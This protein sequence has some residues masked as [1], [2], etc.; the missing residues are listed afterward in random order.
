MPKIKFRPSKTILKTAEY[1]SIFLVAFS[2]LFVVRVSRGLPTEGGTLTVDLQTWDRIARNMVGDTDPG[3]TDTAILKGMLATGAEGSALYKGT[4]NSGEP[5]FDGDLI[6]L[7]YYQLADGTPNVDGTNLFIGTWTPITS[8]TTIG[9]RFDDASGAA[10]ENTDTAN[11]GEF[12]YQIDFTREGTVY[13][14]TALI[15]DNSASGFKDS[16]TISGLGGT[17]AGHLYNLD[18]VTYNADNSI[19]GAAP[20]DEARLGIRVYDISQGA[21]TGWNGSNK[22][23][24]ATKYQ[25]IMHTDWKWDVIAS[26][27]ASTPTIVMDL[28][29]TGGG[30]PT[31]TLKFE[32]DNTDARGA[33]VSKVG[34]GDGSNPNGFQLMDNDFVTT[35]AY[36]DGSGNLDLGNGALGSAIV[37]GFAGS[38]T[39]DGGNDGNMLTLNSAAG[40]TGN[41]AYTFSGNIYQ[42]ATTSTDLTIV[43]E[44]AG[45]QI[46]TGNINVVDSSSSGSTGSTSAGLNIQEG[47]VILK[48]GLSTTQKFEY[49]HGESGTTLTLDNTILA[50]QT[51]ELGFA[52]T[53]FANYAGGDE[54]PTHAGNVVLSGSNSNN[55]IKVV[56]SATADDTNMGKNQVVQGAVSG[57]NKLVKDGVGRLTL[58][59]ASSYSGGTQIDHGTLHAGHNDALGSG[60]VVINKGKLQVGSGIDVSESID[61]GTG[62][63]MIGGDGT[64]SGV[65]STGSTS[66]IAIGS[67]AGYIDTISPGEGISSSLSPSNQQV[68]LGVEG[69]GNKGELAVGTLTVTNLGLY[70]GGVYDWEITD[71]LSG[72]NQTSTDGTDFDVLKFTTLAFDSSGSASFGINAFSVDKTS[73]DAGGVANLGIHSGDDGILFLDG[74]NHAAITWGH[75]NHTLNSGVNNWQQA[76]YFNVDDRGYNYHNGNLYGGWS[77]WYNGSGDFY[78]RYSAVPEPST[79]VMV[80]GLLLVPG[81]RFFRRFGKKG[82]KQED[83]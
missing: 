66:K 16:D 34:T 26:T 2:S 4:D 51:I 35:I 12:Y 79:Y 18:L 63:S 69:A 59:G 49:L 1:T 53:T 72:A 74:P 73:G 11:S 15:N 71:F 6:E 75:S 33:N 41:D 7:G 44:G 64:F 13:G 76:S 28:H 61:G 78:M 10:W 58:E 60:A 55:T 23:L 36:H 37:S 52:N 70:D 68:T 56:S 83:K 43:K 27:G 57:S 29:D 9:A 42:D 25:T 19:G 62:K 47:T 65:T 67:T 54:N 17:G 5:N 45:E 82:I 21:T 32:F 40:N 30:A 22:S 38:G 14:N 48:P 77:V 31:S 46:F 39:I 8:K 81:F 80:M 3:N 50:T 20:G 24:T